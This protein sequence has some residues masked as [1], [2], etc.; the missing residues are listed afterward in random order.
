M[1]A[2]RRCSINCPINVDEKRL[3]EYFC[4]SLLNNL[5]KISDSEVKAYAAE[6]LSRNN[7][8]QIIRREICFGLIPKTLQ[9]KSKYD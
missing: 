5:E 3:V 4:L 8:Q 7:L 9:R 6:F 1:L 2:F